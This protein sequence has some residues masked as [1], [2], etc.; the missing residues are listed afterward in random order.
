M[1]SKGAEANVYKVTQIKDNK[2]YAAKKRFNPASDRKLS[3]SKEDLIFIYKR[4]L[5]EV[6][7]MKTNDHKN[8][9]KFKQAL[10]DS[11]GDLYIIMDFCE[12]GNLY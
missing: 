11:Q 6:E 3:S 12:G 2:V 1:L 4:F 8:I 9:I 10:R 7:N 5:A